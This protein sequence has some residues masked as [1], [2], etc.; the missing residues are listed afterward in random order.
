MPTPYDGKIY[1]V[2]VKG[3]FLVRKSLGDVSRLIVDTMPNVD[4]VFLQT[5][6]GKEWQSKFDNDAKAVNGPDMIKQWVSAMESRSLETHVWGIP[7]GLDVP[8]EADKFIQ[9]A[10]V[11]GVKSLLL[12]VEHGDHYYRGNADAARQLMT[13]IRNALGHNFHI[14]FILD[15]RRN[16]PFNVFI[17]PWLPFMD[18]LHPMIYP[19]DFGKSVADALDTGFS[20]LAAFGKPV[21]PMLQS[22]NGIPPADITLQGN[23]AVK[24][25]AVGLSFFC[26]GDRHMNAPEFA[27]VAAINFSAG[28]QASKAAAPANPLPD[29]AVGRWPDDPRDYTEYVYESAPDRPWHDF[30]DIYGRQARWKLTSASNDVAASYTPQLPA[31]G[32]Y[33]IDVFI[34]RDNADSKR[35]DYHITYYEN[36]QPKERQIKIDQSSKSDEWV[37]LGEFDLDPRRA[38]DG[39]V[40]ITDFSDEQPAQA[41]AFAGVR[42]VP[43]A[44]VGRAV[45]AS[46]AISEV[47]RLALQGSQGSGQTTT[48]ATSPVTAPL[49]S[50]S[51][52]NQDVINA[53]IV[54]GAKFNQKF[55][56]LIGT[57][58]LNSIYANR[59]APYIGP[60]IAALPNIGNDHKAAIAEALRLS[61]AD[62]AKAA[63]NATQPDTPALMPSRPQPQPGQG[64]VDGRIWGVH[65]S[66]GTAVPPRDKWDFWLSE[67]KAMG[68]KWYKQCDSTGPNDTGDGSIFRWVL[69]L[70]DAGIT[71]VVRYQVGHQFPN[72]LDG[73]RFEKMK[74]YVREGIVWAEIGNEPNLPDEWS[75]PKERVSWQKDDCIQAV[76]EAWLADS[77]QALSVNARPAFYALAPVDWGDGRPEQ[78]FSGTKFNERIWGYIG[79]DA[80]RRNRAISIFKRGGWLAVHVAV[81]EFPLDFDPFPQGRGWDM[82]L[83]A[84]EIPMHFIKQNLGLTGGVDYAI[85]STESGVFTPES[86]SMGGHERLPNDDAHASLTLKMYDWLEMNSPLQAMMPWCL[87]VHDDI[88]L[89]NRDYPGDGWY[90]Q[91]DGRLTARSVIGR[92]KGVRNERQAQR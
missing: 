63:I 81:Y 17:D 38:N 6:Q 39:R 10:K 77:E 88:G 80:G 30:R 52:T 69:A 86:H 42:W 9:A 74:H 56:D 5:S 48:P 78:N 2:Q 64:K 62:L 82:C 79:A 66:A 21:I 18:S 40:N 45:P 32:H 53:F 60:A 50:T 73:D 36:N 61:P 76:A 90:L 65:G 28:K 3:S 71:P 27:A 43:I 15:A 12:D 51:T 87:A 92:L 91:R 35:A 84:Y 46:V 54:A 72:R 85:M 23:E 19:R 44:A 1:L 7:H 26:L 14:G 8:T 49:S 55:T 75:W 70:R 37:S 89:N 24:R 4:G 68:I 29:G 47:R 34:P 16:R 33:S 57:A 67:L 83:R 31:P 58:G 11:P 22:Y 41:V 25:G 59:K 20:F 13:L